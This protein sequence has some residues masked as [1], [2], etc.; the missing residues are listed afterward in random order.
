MIEQEYEPLCLC[1]HPL[2]EHVC[3]L[4]KDTWENENNIGCWLDGHKEQ[5]HPCSV[6]GGFPRKSC[7][8]ENFKLD[9]LHYLEWKYNR[10]N[11]V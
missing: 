9:S 2:W 7:D 8:C 10:N 3:Y 4:T 6:R 5:K 1:K 11:N